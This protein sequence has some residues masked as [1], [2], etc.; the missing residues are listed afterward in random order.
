MVWFHGYTDATLF[1]NRFR[2]LSKINRQD[3]ECLS[4][5]R[6]KK[7]A[8]TWINICPIARP[9]SYHAYSSSSSNGDFAALIGVPCFA[10]EIGKTERSSPALTTEPGESQPKATNQSERTLIG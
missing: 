2:C 4:R 5:N 8:M 3:K 10:D 7:A 6:P 9:I 1:Q